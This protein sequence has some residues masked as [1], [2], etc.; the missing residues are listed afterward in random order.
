MGVDWRSSNEEPEWGE[1]AG[2]KEEAAQAEAV[3][4]EPT[5][6]EEMPRAPRAGRNPKDKQRGGESLLPL[7]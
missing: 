2:V 3:A 5:R 1:A 6:A 4:V 7:R